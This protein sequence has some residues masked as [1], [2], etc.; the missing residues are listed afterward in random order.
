MASSR[1]SPFSGLSCRVCFFSPQQ[2]PVLLLRRREIRRPVRLKLFQ[3]RPRPLDRSAVCSQVSHRGRHWRDQREGSPRLDANNVLYYPDAAIRNKKRTNDGFDYYCGVSREV[4]CFFVKSQGIP[5]TNK[6][7]MGLH[8]K[9]FTSLGEN[10]RCSRL[11]QFTACTAW[12]VRE[13]GPR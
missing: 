5:G 8:Y 11:K 1:F 2:L 4:S 7:S 9:N 3:V 10:F 12:L 13:K 6:S